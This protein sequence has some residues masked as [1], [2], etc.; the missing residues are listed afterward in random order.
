[1]M[2]F[3]VEVSRAVRS[4]KDSLPPSSRAPIFHEKYIKTKGVNNSGFSRRAM[5]ALSENRITPIAFLG[6]ACG[7]LIGSLF[8]KMG[9]ESFSELARQAENGIRLAW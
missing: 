8:R 1:M 7:N 5:A 2:V 9:S 4:E 3:G 6:A